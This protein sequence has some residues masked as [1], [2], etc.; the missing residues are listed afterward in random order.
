MSLEQNKGLEPIKPSGAGM[1]SPDINYELRTFLHSIMGY[2]EILQEDAAAQGQENLAPELE[3]IWLASNQ[4][5][6]LVEEK[7]PDAPTA[8]TNMGLAPAS[9]S[10]EEAGK[11]L[12]S[13]ILAPNQQQRE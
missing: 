2:I 13:R 8:Y 7:F 5:A 1:P 6:A 11:W 9:L 10:R 12:R 4:L 3:K